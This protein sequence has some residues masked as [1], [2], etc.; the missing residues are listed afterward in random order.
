MKQ[1]M[2]CQLYVIYRHKNE[3]VMLTLFVFKPKI[4]VT[5]GVLYLTYDGNLNSKNKEW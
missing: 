2:L 1:F 4:N 5:L 3:T